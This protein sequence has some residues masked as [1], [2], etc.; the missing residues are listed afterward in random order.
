MLVSDDS[1]LMAK[2]KKLSTQARE[3]ELHYEHKELGYNYRMSNIIAAI[4]RGQ[5][6]VLSERVE[7]RQRVFEAYRQGL[8]DL[9]GIEFMPEPSWS[10]STRWL[11]CFT[12]NSDYGDVFDPVSL[13]EFLD[14]RNIE[15][16][17]LWKPLHMQPLMSNYPVFGSKIF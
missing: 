3:P 2:A 15:A 6:A 9:T 7:L 12:V 1:G 17:P 10:V 5:L 16:R 13:V 4:C 14:R 8:S 11:T